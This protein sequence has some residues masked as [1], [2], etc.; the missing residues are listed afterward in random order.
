MKHS[1]KTNIIRNNIEYLL[2]SRGETQVSLSGGSGINRT[3]IYKILEGK[4]INIQDKTLKKVANFFGVSYSE[5]QNTNLRSKDQEDTLVSLDGNM[6]PIAVPILSDAVILSTI[7][8]KIGRLIIASPITYFFGDGPNVIGITLTNGISGYY[9]KGDVIIIK[10]GVAIKDVSL[11][12]LTRNKSLKVIEGQQ[13]L[14]DGEEL[15]G[16]I[17]EERYG[18]QQKI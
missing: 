18:S 15:I 7:N 16:S 6:N 17:I 14:M 13:L 1:E 8:K 4:V 11:L 5:I 12:V 10:R 3:T 2:E 9:E